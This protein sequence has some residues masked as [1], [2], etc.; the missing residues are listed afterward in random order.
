LTIAPFA[1]TR[2]SCSLNGGIL[3]DF[4]VAGEGLV[5]GGTILAPLRHDRNGAPEIAIDGAEELTG[6]DTGKVMVTVSTKPGS[7]K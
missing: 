5:L 4:A 2:D 1:C 6:M 7:P 3:D